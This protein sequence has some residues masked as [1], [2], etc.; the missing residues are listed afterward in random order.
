MIKIYLFILSL[1]LGNQVCAQQNGFK[2][3]DTLRNK[4]YDYLFERAEDLEKDSVK[5]SLY[6]RTFLLKATSEKNSEEIVNGYK[7]Y[8]HYSPENLKLVYAD[9]M[10]YAAKKSGDN[11]LIGSAYLSKGIVYYAQKK[12]NYALNNYL[13]ANNFISKTN[14]TYLIYKVKYNI[15][16]IKYYL[17][18]YDEAL[19]LFRECITY[20]KDENARAYLNSL[21]LIGLCY[22]KI[23]N[24]GLCSETNEKGLAEG[25]RLATNEM[26]S[27]FIHSEGINQYFKN[28]YATAIKKITYSLPAIRENEDFANESVGYFYI[29]KSYWALKKPKMALLYFRKVDEIFDAKSYIRPD[30]LE[31]YELIIKYYKS[32]NNLNAQLHYIEKLLKAD[33]ILDTKYEYLSGRIRKEYDT[34]EIL[35]E[36]NKIENLLDRR[37]YNDFIFISVI[38]F[39]FLSIL[40]LAYRHIRN[41]NMYR[42]KFDELMKKSEV[43]KAPVKNIKKGILD[44]NEDTAASIL[45]QL[46]KFE[47]D[48][49]F[50]EK[51]LTLGKLSTAFDS[52]S[53]YL[54]QIIYHYRGKNFTKYINDLKVDYIISL[55]K[56]DKMMRNYTNKALAE[57]IGFSST[58]RFANAF[59]ARA[60]MPPSF[61]IGELKKV[62][63]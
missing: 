14:D 56:T 37:K 20:F 57:E 40:F 48:K 63:S 58:Q 22:N 42:Q 33:R 11:A 34:K 60:E 8:V 38:T 31:N 3:P 51:D 32:Q 6:L 1:C 16:N 21:H 44:I 9:S 19:S 2:I 43:S 27:Y 17:R 23:G 61:F 52:N 54:S 5:Q 24:Y 46:E 47:R 45:K 62:H 26:E 7:N 12:H 15:A 41:K 39:L 53:K 28:N 50:L 10:I 18:F 55:L 35:S 13:I 30:L 29:G 49:K 59:L 4:N 25:K 36:K